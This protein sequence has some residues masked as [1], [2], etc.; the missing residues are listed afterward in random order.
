LKEHWRNPDTFTVARLVLEAAY[1]T[2]RQLAEA[3]P[4][5]PVTSPNRAPAAQNMEAQNGLD[6]HA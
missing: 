6:I 5:P 1:P 4:A 3:W 2:D